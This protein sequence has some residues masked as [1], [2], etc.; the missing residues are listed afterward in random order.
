MYS[1]SRR[2]AEIPSELSLALPCRSL[3]H[4]YVHPA[5]DAGCKMPDT[6]LHTSRHATGR[7]RWLARCV[8]TP[9]ACLPP[10][11]H[12]SLL[13]KENGA[14]R[15]LIEHQVRLAAACSQRCML[16]GPVIYA[17]APAASPA[18]I[19]LLRLEITAGVASA[20]R[21]GSGGWTVSRVGRRAEAAAPERAEACG[22]AAD[23][24]E[25]LCCCCA[26]QLAEEA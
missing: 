22:S 16:F 8:R 19:A 21:A 3:C 9:L 7:H 1:V 12:D 23:E 25:R 14:Y 10:G 13:L 17:A 11:T 4:A 6:T 20:R 15:R 24:S 26:D 2:A 5:I 18:L